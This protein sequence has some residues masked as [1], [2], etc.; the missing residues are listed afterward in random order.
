MPFCGDGDP[1]RTCNTRD[2]TSSWIPGK[3]RTRVDPSPLLGDWIN[4]NGTTT[5]I[6]RVAISRDRDS[7]SIS[8]WPAE[9]PSRADPR[10]RATADVVYSNGPTATAAMALSAS[11]KD[12]S[13]DTQLEG[14]PELGPACHRHLPHVQER[15]RTIELLFARGFLSLRRRALDL[16]RCARTTPG[17]VT[18]TGGR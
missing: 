16:G 11:Y 17:A 4:T 9:M 5:G 3:G 2:A 10:Y 7:V 12:E 8:I 1:R 6:A 14:E 13:L 18:R 15:W